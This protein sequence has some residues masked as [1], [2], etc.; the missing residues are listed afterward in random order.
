M[1][2]PSFARYSTLVGMLAELTN[3]FVLNAIVIL[4]YTDAMLF[5]PQTS[6]F[7]ADSPQNYRDV[8]LKK[9]YRL[10]SVFFIPIVEFV[11]KILL[12][13]VVDGVLPLLETT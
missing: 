8:T 6:V 2:P 3:T 9:K 4:K 1:F 11:P 10:E 5:V 13:V 12:T 7:A